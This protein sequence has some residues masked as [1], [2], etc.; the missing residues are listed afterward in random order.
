MGLFNNLFGGK[1]SNSFQP[2]L[3]EEYN[4]MDNITIIETSKYKDSSKY[5]FQEQGIFKDL[6]DSDTTCYRATF[7]FKLNSDDDQYPL[8]DILDKYFLHVTDFYENENL[9][10]NYFLREL[11]GELLDLKDALE[12][13]GKKVYNKDVFD[14]EI[15]VRVSLVIE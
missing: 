9:D 12:I 4:V 1:K 14:E 3:N 11:A 8:E 10:K 15:K 5:S 7:S 2:K 6:N 13:V